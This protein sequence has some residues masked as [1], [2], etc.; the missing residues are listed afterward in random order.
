MSTLSS[1]LSHTLTK[2]LDGTAKK[3]DHQIFLVDN[4]KPPDEDRSVQGTDDGNEQEE[5]SYNGNRL[6]KRWTAGS[7]RAELK[8]RK[9]AKYQE[10]R[11]TETSNAKTQSSRADTFMTANEN[12]PSDREPTRI[13]S[14]QPFRLDRDIYR[15]GR[16]H[17]SY[18]KARIS[19]LVKGRRAAQR[20]PDADIVVDI[21]YENQR[22]SFIFGIPLFSSNSLLQI[23]PTSWQTCDPANRNGPSSKSTDDSNSDP[24]MRNEPQANAQSKSNSKS[25]KPKRQIQP[26]FRPSIVDITNAQVPDPCWEWVWPCWYVDMAHDV[27]EEGWEYSFSFGTPYKSYGWH[28][29]QKPWWHSFVR[30]RRW[31]R[32]RR[33]KQGHRL[34]DLAEKGERGEREFHKAHMLNAE[35]FTIHPAKDRGEVGSETQTSFT[36]IFPQHEEE[37]DTEPDI[38]DIAAL[39]KR[40]K[41]AAIDRE[42]IVTVKNFLRN[43]GQ[44]VFYLAE[45]MPHIMSLFIFQASRRH[46]L[47]LLMHTFNAA[48]SHREQ[49]TSSS[50]PESP[51][52]KT[53]IDNL[54]NA[55]RAADAQVRDLEFWSDIKDI[56]REGGSLDSP[57]FHRGWG[58]DW[59]GIDQSGPAANGNGFE[60]KEKGDATC[61]GQKADPEEEGKE[62]WEDVLEEL[63]SEEKGV[64]R[65]YE[66]DFGQTRAGRKENEEPKK[67]DKGKGKA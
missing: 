7:V 46:L 28:G 42:K 26:V 27:D 58:S 54:L 52:E 47:A 34:E 10:G 57:D 45:Y 32:M 33:R 67:L 1:T 61:G 16:D 21:L 17:I 2:T 15:R 56:V 20:G 48:S 9:Y 41:N 50:R 66:H 43:G 13:S 35:Y 65:V 5:G 3:Y 64:D 38:A 24:L 59:Q 62:A 53:Y 40:L 39:M 44:D 63:H 14:E 8:R 30:R 37:D 31:I 18:R 12:P 51:T 22:G 55:V 11:E 6:T 4:T 29:T 60:S 25:K 36:G 19:Q 49:H 23:D